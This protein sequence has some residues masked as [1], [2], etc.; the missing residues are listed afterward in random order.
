MSL[1]W[2]R[3]VYDEFLKNINAININDTTNLVTKSNYDTKI[4]ET[5]KKIFDDHRKYITTQELNKLMADYFDT[6][7]NKQI[8]QLK[9]LL[10]ILLK[11]Q[12]FGGK[13]W[14]LWWYCWFCKDFNDKLKKL[15]KKVTL[16]K[17]KLHLLKMG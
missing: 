10:L 4:S 16:N 14:W 8:C 2:S 7:L 15:N 17:T 12:D 5:E 1:T 3:N 9:L 13:F 6:R 11:K